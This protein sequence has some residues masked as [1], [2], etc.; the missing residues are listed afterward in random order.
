MG[1]SSIFKHSFIFTNKNIIL[2]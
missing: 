1:L 2:K